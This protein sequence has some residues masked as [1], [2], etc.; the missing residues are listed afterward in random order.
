MQP[1]TQQPHRR[2]A[3]EEVERDH[4]RHRH[5]GEAPGGA[6]CVGHYVAGRRH[7]DQR[8]DE[9]DDQPDDAADLAEL[10]RRAQEQ[11]GEGDDR[12][13]QHPQQRGID[14]GVDQRHDADQDDGREPD[15][16][17][18]DADG[19]DRVRLHQE[20]DQV[21]AQRGFRD[22]IHH[23]G[24]GN[25]RAEQRDPPGE[26]RSPRK[27]REVGDRPREERAPPGGCCIHGQHCSP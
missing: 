11:E 17:E 23:R 18:C 6:Q 8:E 16:A 15:E 12:D 14:R 24:R 27:G 4:Q 25:D 19:L 1:V 7:A 21:A 3:Q 26:R 9:G 10:A 20:D 22:L 5:R 13:G 2:E